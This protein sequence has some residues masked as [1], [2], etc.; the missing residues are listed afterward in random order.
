V[1]K[2]KNEFGSLREALKRLVRG[3]RSLF[4]PFKKPGSMP[5]PLVSSAASFFVFVRR[6]DLAADSVI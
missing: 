1:L 6:Q 4:I 2:F 5:P 3:Q